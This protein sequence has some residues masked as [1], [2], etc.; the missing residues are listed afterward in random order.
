MKGPFFV[1]DK[2]QFIPAKVCQDCGWLAKDKTCCM[3]DC[4]FIGYSD[5]MDE[6]GKEDQKG[7]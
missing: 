2:D 1:K 5:E 3:Q 4:P 6:E 7:E